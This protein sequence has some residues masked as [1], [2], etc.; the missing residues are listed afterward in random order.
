MRDQIHFFPSPAS[1]GGSAVAL[2][3]AMGADALASLRSNSEQRELRSAQEVRA[4]IPPSG[5][6]P[7]EKWRKE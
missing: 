5:Y 1:S 6:S 7:H 2:A 3:Q 4:P